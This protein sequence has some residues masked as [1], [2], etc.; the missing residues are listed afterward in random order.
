MASDL[1]DYE[2]I[3]GVCGGI[4]AYKVC[5][6]VSTLAQRGAGVQVA[7]TKA[8]RKFHSDNIIRISSRTV[9]QVN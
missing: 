9:Q 1:K 5:S 3:V 6:V 8:A 4:A 2:V 7:M